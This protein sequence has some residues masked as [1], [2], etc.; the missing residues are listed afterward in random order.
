MS[1]RL[2]RRTVLD[3]VLNGAALVGLVIA[4]VLRV[5]GYDVAATVVFFLAVVPGVWAGWRAYDR[6][7]DGRRGQ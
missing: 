6:E 1:Q 4:V 5:A 3:T 2:P 7:P